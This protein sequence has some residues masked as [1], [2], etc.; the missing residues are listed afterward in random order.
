VFATIDETVITA[1]EYQRIFRAAV[2]NRYYHGKVPEPELA[3][4]QREVGRDVVNQFLVHKEALRQGMTPDTEQIQSGIDKY[5]ARYADKPGWQEQRERQLPAM[6]IQL[7][8][9]DLLL[10]MEE[11]IKDLPQ[12]GPAEVEAYYQEHPDKFTEPERKHVSIILL[13][14]QPSAGGAVWEET[15]GRV[16][17]LRFQLIE[18]ADF[19]ELAQAN[20]QDFSAPNGGDLGFL[21]SGMLADEA[22][23]ALAPLAVGEIT[24]PI[25]MLEGVALFRLNDRTPATLQSF[26][27]VQQRAVALQH[28]E[29]QDRAWE[30]Y[31]QALRSN[32]T[33]ELNETLY[34]PLAD[35]GATQ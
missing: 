7:E 22:E 26:A 12:P 25:A 9:R 16:A 28:R 4:F 23:T 10:Q 19:S 31:L 27:D 8:R 18:G 3:R 5:D 1:V 35:A 32:A 30:A 34:M 11:K 20:S 24:E 6:L 21:H 15:A 13:R 17:A 14:V 29:R 33:I 2:R